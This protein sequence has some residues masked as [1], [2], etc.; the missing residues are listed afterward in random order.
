[1]QRALSPEQYQSV[2]HTVCCR[3]LEAL[4]AIHARLPRNGDGTTDAAPVLQGYFSALLQFVAPHWDDA[5][6]RAEIAAMIDQQLPQIRMHM[7]AGVHGR[8]EARA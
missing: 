2:S 5:R 6:I 3:Q 7:A 4:Q 1:M 8:T